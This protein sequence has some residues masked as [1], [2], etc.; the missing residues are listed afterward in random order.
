MK[1][2]F[3]TKNS[4]VTWFF[5]G[6]KNRQILFT[7]YISYMDC[8]IFLV[9]AQIYSAFFFWVLKFIKK[10]KWNCLVLA[11]TLSIS[12][13]CRRSST[14]FDGG[15]SFEPVFK[16]LRKLP[17]SVSGFIKKTYLSYL[18]SS[19]FLSGVLTDLWKWSKKKKIES[20]SS[21][22]SLIH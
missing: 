21:L 18:N 3:Q 13:R 17:D 9:F 22:Y 10:K 4:R 8:R 7:L 5:N 1:S 16:L 19:R 2:H 15:R 12:R 6:E 11:R 14:E 20:L